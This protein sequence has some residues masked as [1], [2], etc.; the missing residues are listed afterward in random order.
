MLAAHGY[1]VLLF[2]RRGEGESEGDSNLFGWGGDTLL[3]F[4]AD[5]AFLAGMGCFAAG[6]VCYLVLFR[7]R[8]RGAPPGRARGR[9]LVIG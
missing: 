2:D 3:L 7:T 9:L 4:D 5:P 1:G 8:G 6:H